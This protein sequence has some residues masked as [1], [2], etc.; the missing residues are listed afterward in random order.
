MSVDSINIIS[1]L[2]RISVDYY[3]NIHQ[4]N[5]YNELK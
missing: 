5:L 1:Q 2:A 4:M 3:P